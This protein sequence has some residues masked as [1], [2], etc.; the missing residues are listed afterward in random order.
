MEIRTLLFACL[1]GWMAQSVLAQPGPAKP[2]PNQ[3]VPTSEA[4]TTSTVQMVPAREVTFSRL[5]GKVGARRPAPVHHRLDRPAGTAVP[6]T[7]LL[8]RAKMG[9]STVD[10]KR[11]HDGINSAQSGFPVSDNTVAVGPKVN[12][13]RQI[14]EVTNGFVRLTDQT[15]LELGS[16]G[17]SAFLGVTDGSLVFDPRAVYDPYDRRFIIAVLRNVLGPDLVPTSSTQF[18]AFSPQD[19]ALAGSWLIIEVTNDPG[20][21]GVSGDFIDVGFTRGLIGTSANRF[22][23]PISGP[24]AVGVLYRAFGK[25]QPDGAGGFQVPVFGVLERT[26]AAN[27][28]AISMRVARSRGL[29]HDFTDGPELLFAGVPSLIGTTFNAIHL[30]S[31]AVDGT[32]ALVVADR[33]LP[34]PN[35]ANPNVDAP[36]P[37]ACDNTLDVSDGRLFNLEG[38]GRSFVTAHTVNDG[39]NTGGIGDDDTTIRWY[40]IQVD[41]DF[42]AGAQLVET[43]TVDLGAGIFH[44]VPSI[45]IN[46]V[47]EIGMIFG[48]VSASEP[49]SLWITGRSP[50]DDA[51]EMAPPVQIEVGASCFDVA[52]SPAPWMHYSQV[53]PVENVRRFWAVGQTFDTTT[54]WET[55]I[56]EFVVDSSCPECTCDGA[57]DGGVGE[58]PISQF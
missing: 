57:D 47:G 43:G 55:H 44:S 15:G 9:G 20:L 36:Q 48:A 29:S 53:T 42:L 3:E 51:G 22:T 40:H 28:G 45:A 30:T 38:N 17:L 6:T 58:N 1:A 27:A 21:T 49:A 14:L 24:T 35:F 32:G 7:S 13:K 39:N 33:D 31:I 19:D 10:P 11:S 52:G 23:G 4:S 18:L 5:P 56:Q 41:A 25:P 8:P 34:V 46:S 37:A 54:T 12:G 16:M 50:C 26:I 2:V